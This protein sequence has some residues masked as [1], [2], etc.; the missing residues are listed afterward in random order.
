[1]N[2]FTPYTAYTILNWDPGPIEWIW[3]RIIPVGSLFLLAGYMKTGK[4]TFAYPL[5]VS[6][7]QGRAFLD[8]NTRR[9]SVLILALEEQWV[10]V[11]SRLQRF[12]MQP[13]DPIFVHCGPLDYTFQNFS[14]KTLDGRS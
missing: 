7:A 9:S 3:E 4:S 11:R 6:V 14:R 13:A 8:L 10:D 1:M 12:G 5:A 2:T